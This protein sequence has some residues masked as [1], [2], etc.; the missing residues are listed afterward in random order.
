MQLTFIDV[1]AKVN[2]P[3]A[4]IHITGKLRFNKEAEKLMQ[5]TE[6]GD[7]LPC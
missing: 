3:K 5:L 6:Q 2:I 4:A 7:W 1:D